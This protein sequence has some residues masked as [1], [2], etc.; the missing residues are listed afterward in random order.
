MQHQ[1][2]GSRK[3]SLLPFVFWTC[4]SV[5]PIFPQTQTQGNPLSLYFSFWF[6]FF[7]F[8]LFI[9]GFGWLILFYLILP[10]VLSRFLIYILPKTKPRILFLQLLS[11]MHIYE[12]WSLFLMSYWEKKKKNQKLSLGSQPNSRKDSN[13]KR[14]GEGV[15]FVHFPTWIL[16][17]L[18]S[19]LS[20][21]LI[22]TS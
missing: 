21:V 8:G 9:F 22:I 10:L 13:S 16:L 3:V 11:F 19:S 15:N 4:F 1:G 17:L 5:F 2:F 20:F 6:F 18:V 14:W 7:F 12:A